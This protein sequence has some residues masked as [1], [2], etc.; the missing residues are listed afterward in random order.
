MCRGC[1]EKEPR[2]VLEF[3]DCETEGCNNRISSLS[4]LGVCRPCYL[5]QYEREKSRTAS[6]FSSLGE[7]WKL[8]E[9]KPLKFVPD[10]KTNTVSRRRQHG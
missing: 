2:A 9:A 5:R 10:Y 8:P 6:D 4:R 7:H 1:Y 3:R